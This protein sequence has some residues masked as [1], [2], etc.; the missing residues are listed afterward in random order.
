MRVF[1]FPALCQHAQICVG[2][3]RRTSA[4]PEITFP[5]RPLSERGHGAAGLHVCQAAV[6]SAVPGAGVLHRT[7]IGRRRNGLRLPWPWRVW[8]HPSVRPAYR[9]SASE[10]ARM[11]EHCPP[12]TAC[13]VLIYTSLP[14]LSPLVNNAVGFKASA[15]IRRCCSSVSL[16]QLLSS[17]RPTFS[18]LGVWHLKRLV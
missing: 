8:F 7:G 10:P 4:A 14:I 15:L 13:P 16:D 11:M 6:G 1:N 17:H 12:V 5:T 2:G 3:R 9:L 18:V